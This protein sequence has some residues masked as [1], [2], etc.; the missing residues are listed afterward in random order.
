MTKQQRLEL[1]RKKNTKK[2]FKQL[3]NLVHSQSAD[4]GIK[5]TK[6]SG[7]F[8]NHWNNRAQKCP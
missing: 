6:S 7:R 3:Q 2:Q 8:W 1:R 5:V 4:P